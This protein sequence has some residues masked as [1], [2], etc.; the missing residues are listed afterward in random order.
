MAKSPDPP[1][2]E[3]LDLLERTELS[4][5]EMVGR[6]QDG[7]PA[8]IRAELMEIARP[9]LRTLIRAGRR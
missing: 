3:L 9:L 4:L 5:W 1:R 2:R 8:P 6:W 7:I